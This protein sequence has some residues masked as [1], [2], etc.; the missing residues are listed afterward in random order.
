MVSQSFIQISRMTNIKPIIFFRDQNICKELFFHFTK[1]SDPPDE[2]RDALPA[3]LLSLI[4]YKER[5]FLQG[6][7]KAKEKIKTAKY[8][9]WFKR[10]IN[11]FNSHPSILLLIHEFARFTYLKN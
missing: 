5:P 4:C 3:E 7:C 10:V 6:D 2:Y 11:Q 1:S 8:F 9:H